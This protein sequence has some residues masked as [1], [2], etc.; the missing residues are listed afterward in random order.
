MLPIRD[1]KE[2]KDFFRVQ[3]IALCEGQKVWAFSLMA[4]FFL[5]CG[6]RTTASSC[7]AISRKHKKVDHPK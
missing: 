6:A 3:K 7:L 2:A 1:S 5:S 4:V